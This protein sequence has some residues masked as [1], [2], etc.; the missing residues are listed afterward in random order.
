M[1]ED[2]ENKL[3][4]FPLNALGKS[5]INKQKKRKALLDSAYSLFTTIGF[6]K[7]TILNIAMKAGV[8][9]GTFYNYFQ[10]KED[11]RD[12]LI[13]VKASQ[14][15]DQAVRRLQ[16][17]LNEPGVDM[18][19]S[20]KLIFLTDVIISS[21]ARDLALLRFLS[22]SLSW[23]LLRNES[24]HRDED[25]VINFRTF[26]DEAFQKEGVHLRDPELLIFTL[27]ATISAT[28]DEVILRGEPVPFSEYKPYLYDTIRTLVRHATLP[29]QEEAPAPAE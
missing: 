3:P 15:L 7:T 18:D 25:G 17:K 22:K 21:L 6:H 28:I 16:Q 5:A 1:F 11:I 29:S 14:I 10:D 20:D 13:R 2:I 27:L 24:S 12:E 19:F 23:G 4:D 26:V 8:G 9:K